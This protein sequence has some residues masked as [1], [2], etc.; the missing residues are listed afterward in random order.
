MKAEVIY[1][2]EKTKGAITLQVEQH[3][4]P[5][6]QKLSGFVRVDEQHTYKKGDIIDIPAK[7]AWVEERVS[8][9]GE[10]FK[11]LKFK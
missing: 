2:S 7:E 1:V 9:T 6:K 8:E 3:F 5:I 11:F 10:P 4:G